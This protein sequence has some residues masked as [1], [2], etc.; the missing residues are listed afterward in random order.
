MRGP[1][2]IVGGRVY[3]P[4]NGV[5]GEVR[6]VCVQ[7]G[8][9][10]A[11]LPDGVPTLDARGRVVMPGGVDIHCHIVGSAVNTSRL[12]E[13]ERHRDDPLRRRVWEEE[14]ELRVLRSGTGGL[15]P[16]TFATGYRYAG[17][18]YTTAFDAAVPALGARQ[19]HQE[20]N[21]TPVIDKGFY[22]LLGND[23]F[24]LRLLTRR[25]HELVRHYLAW[26]VRAARA[27]AVKVVNPGGIAAW[28]Q[29]ELVS[30]LDER[31][32]GYDVTPREIIRAIAGAVDEIGLPHPMHLHCNNL[33]MPGNAAT[34]LE[35]MRALEGRRTHFAHLQFHGYGG[36]PEERPTSQVLPLIEHLNAHPEHSCDVGQVMFGDAMTLSADS[37]VEQ[38]LHQLTGKRW[39]D[40]DVE[41]ET[42]CG[43]VPYEYKHRSYMHSLQWAMGLELFL[44]SDDPWRVVLSTDHPNGGSF[45]AYPRLIRLLMDRAYRDDQLRRVN[46]D[47]L[48]GTAL[49]DGLGREYSLYEIA[50]VTRAG[51]ARLLGLDRKGHLGP[52][53]DADVTVYDPDPDAEVMFS[54]P[55]YV[56]K[57]GALIVEEGELRR[58]VYGP[59]R[60]VEAE[61]DDAV[62]RPLRRFLDEH[63]TLELDDYRIDEEEL[64]AAEPVVPAPE[65]GA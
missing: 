58:E 47:A 52:G 9:I 29:G 1:L 37:R 44:L 3:D 28:K 22:L 54:T 23:D 60:H 26:M 33:G 36:S 17:L 21:D 45:L 19:A 13:P 2:R 42:G 5:D 46:P 51:P 31:I 12:I 65:G 41:L 40:L 15:T 16:S 62:E 56:I 10:V 35:T 4:R 38:L 55:R 20:L 39:I 6:D 8:R 14:G 63:G 18:G 11:D 48:E 24:L 7:D 49:A 34:T 43:I 30:G 61:F 57:G 53:A 32:P 59:T 25:E 50:I 27:Y 64:R